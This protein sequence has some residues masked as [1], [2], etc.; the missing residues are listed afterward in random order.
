MHDVKEQW[1]TD[2]KGMMKIWR[3]DGEEYQEMINDLVERIKSIEGQKVFSG[4]FEINDRYDR[5]SS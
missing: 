2:F 3:K 4:K 1:D 5:F